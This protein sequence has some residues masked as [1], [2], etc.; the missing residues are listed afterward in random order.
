MTLKAEPGWRVMLRKPLVRPSEPQDMPGEALYTLRVMPIRFW[1]FT[2]PVFSEEL[3]RKPVV[4]DV[5]ALLRAVS[6]LG[7]NPFMK[8]ALSAAT[9]ITMSSQVRSEDLMHPV[10]LGKSRKRYEN[11]IDVIEPDETDKQALERIETV[12]EIK[13]TNKRLL[14]VYAVME[15]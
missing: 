5:P 12:F 2:L 8:D 15:S 11:V 13:R 4:L 10:P 9:L 6:D 14:Q 7:T 3:R 1:G